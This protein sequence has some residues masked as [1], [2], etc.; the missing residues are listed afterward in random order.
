MILTN[1]QALSCNTT[2]EALLTSVPGITAVVM[3]FSAKGILNVV[4]IMNNL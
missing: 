4:E 3:Q 1:E 2:Q